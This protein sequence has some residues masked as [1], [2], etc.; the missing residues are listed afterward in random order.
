VNET[1]VETAGL[2]RPADIPPPR[3][4]PAGHW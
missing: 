4:L 3:G 2:S 1:E